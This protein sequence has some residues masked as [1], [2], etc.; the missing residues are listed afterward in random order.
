MK[1]SK[2]KGMSSASFHIK[3]VGYLAAAQSFQAGT[4]VLLLTNNLIKKA[5]L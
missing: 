4:E 2:S 3:A 1:S 5:R